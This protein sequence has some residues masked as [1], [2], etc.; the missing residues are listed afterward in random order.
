MFLLLNYHIYTTYQLLHYIEDIILDDIE[1]NIDVNI[2]IIYYI[3]NYIL[4]I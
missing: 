4:V 3:F 1:I 2:T